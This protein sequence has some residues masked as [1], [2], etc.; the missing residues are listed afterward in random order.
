MIPKAGLLIQVLRQPLVAATIAA[1]L[2]ISAVSPGRRPT[3][4][5]LAT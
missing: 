3:E 2:V 1:I 4:L 5:R